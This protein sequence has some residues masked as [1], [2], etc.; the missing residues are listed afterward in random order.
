VSVALPESALSWRARLRVFVDREL[1]PWEEEA[2]LNDGV[3]PEAVRARQR[4][5]ALEMGLPGMDAPRGRGGLALP[6]LD[7]VM[8]HDQIGRVTNGLGWCFGE[9]QG[10][11]FEACSE[12]Q[13][14]DYVLGILR[15]TRHECYAITE[16]GPGSDVASLEATA[17]RDGGDYLLSGEKWYVTSFNLA[18]FCFFQAVLA[19][20]PRDGEH[21]LFLVDLDRPGIETVRTPRFSHTFEAH[22]PI[23]RFTDVRVPAA[24]LVGAEG[25]GMAASG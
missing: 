20:G 24:A 10:W 16:A 1:I 11:M 21:A 22:H 6:I 18:D 3:L 12:A 25:E 2:E 15:G 8:I 7:Q 17:R 13:I 5:L 23:V 4:R 19:D 14:E 9:A